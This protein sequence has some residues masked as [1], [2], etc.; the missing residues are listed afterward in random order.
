MDSSWPPASRQQQGWRMPPSAAPD[1]PAPARR[2]QR[3]RREATIR[4]LLDATTEALIE[5]GYYNSSVQ[6]ICSRA[7]VSQG[8]LFRH[9][10][11]R[12]ALM[13]RV[14]QDV[15]DALIVLFRKDFERLRG[16]TADEL[17][18]ALE[19]LRANV[20]SR[21]HQAWFEL[22]MAART[23][24]ALNEALTPVWKKRDATIQQLAA[25]LL[26]EAAQRPPQFA[27]IVDTLVTLFHG[28][29][30]DRFLRR[31]ARAEKLRMDWL[32]QQ[33]QVLLASP[34]QA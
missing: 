33:L 17:G 32:L 8:A 2:T 24:T 29:G 27:V 23:D 20:Q 9:F 28:E 10:E 34:Q 30:M 15:G 5:V 6:A 14:A 25:A 16:K 19:L 26:P 13:I 31:D 21:L 12:L 18:L 3:E 7:G 22:L 4:R 1:A 11:S